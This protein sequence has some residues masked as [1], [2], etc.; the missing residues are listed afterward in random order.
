MRKINQEM[1]NLK[2]IKGIYKDIDNNCNTL[3][4]MILV[5]KEL[6]KRI[7]YLKKKFE[8]DIRE[9]H[10]VLR[11]R[12]NYLF[13][14][15]THKPIWYNEEN[16]EGV[17]EIPP[18]KEILIENE[19]IIKKAKIKFSKGLNIIVGNSAT[20]KTT[21]I[22]YL[23]K[24]YKSMSAGSRKVF[25]VKRI[26]N[27]TT[28]LLDDSLQGLNEEKLIGALKELV[29]SNKQIITTLSPQNLNLIKK[30]IKANIIKTKEFE[31][32]N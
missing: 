11:E 27:N 25:D 15:R 8:E 9:I 20:G 6:M 12:D 29:N 31:L 13:G 24:R 22:R 26:L 10:M 19:G 23:I 3:E 17:F 30:K 4:K 7:D 18:I 5:Q 2:Y 21:V 28:L 32:N 16:K 14:T 1:K